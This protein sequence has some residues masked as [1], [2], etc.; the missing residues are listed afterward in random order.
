MIMR[1]GAGVGIDLAEVCRVLRDFNGLGEVDV[2]TNSSNSSSF[3]TCVL[4]AVSPARFVSDGPCP[5]DPA[6]AE[7][8]V[9]G[10]EPEDDEG[11]GGAGLNLY[12]QV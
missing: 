10:T 9:L 8:R 7:V 3:R 5:D 2:W 1:E 11:S 12:R 4:I 6:I